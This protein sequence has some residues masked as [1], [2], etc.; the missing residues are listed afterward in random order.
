MTLAIDYSC[1]AA[2]EPRHLSAAALARLAGE[3]RMRLFGNQRSPV[4]VERLIARTA[5]LIV[6]TRPM[7]L[8][9]DFD[10]PIHDDAEHEALGACEIDPEL[11]GTVMIS[12]NGSLLAGQAEVIR[13]TAV[14]EFAHA[15]FDMPSALGRNVRRAFRTSI[16]P[17]I[18]K[19]GAAIAWAEW[20]AD[21]F[22]GAFLVPPSR[23]ARVLPRHAG[24]LELPVR[25][26]EGENGQ[27]VPFVD[28][29]SSEGKLGPLVDDLAEVFGVMP[30]FMAV[31]LHKG[32]FIG[33]RF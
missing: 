33:R 5:Q 17:A 2:G 16:A 32:G 1:T 14:H 15:I 31:R 23:L 13:S 25:W 20:R 11:P 10:H 21:E 29:D 22:M 3:L 24:A 9:W 26:R 4:D 12:V 19:P 27:S 6:N 30:A 28:L 8:S 18:A 7:V